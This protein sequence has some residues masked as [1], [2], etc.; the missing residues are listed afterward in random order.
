V[1]E[2][3]LHQPLRDIKTR[4]GENHTDD[5]RLVD[6]VSGGDTGAFEVLIRRYNQRLY[7]IARS[8][9]LDDDEVEDVMQ[10]AYVKAYAN[11]P[12]FEK[13]ARLSTWLTRIV[14]NEALGRL[15]YRKRFSSLSE[16]GVNEPEAGLERPEMET[17]MT[18]V[19]NSELREILEKAVDRLPE[20]YSTVFLM[21]EVEGMS[22]AET[23]ECLSITET[24]VKVRLNRAKEMLRDS[25]GGFY[26]EAG[27]F[28]FDLVR[29][30][31]IVGSVLLRI[32][33]SR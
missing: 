18:K 29:C 21:R 1:E 22:V 24:N 27:A 7:R 28:T 6:M 3:M 32:S 10:E 15:K 2:T 20:K 13:R 30:D 11:L 33:G 31:R 17:P 9:I 4:T 25:I 26:R 12:R 16:D 5:N 23:S 14:I 8:Y 19:M